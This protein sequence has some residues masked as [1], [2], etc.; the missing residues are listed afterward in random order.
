MNLSYS[1][2]ESR[3]FLYDNVWWDENGIKTLFYN[4][5]GYSFRIN[6]FD[7]EIKYNNENY[8]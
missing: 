1:G 4:F 2:R 6:L 8:F 3:D 7:C 5:V